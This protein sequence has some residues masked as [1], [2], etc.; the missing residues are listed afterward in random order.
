MTNTATTAKGARVTLLRLADVKQRTGIGKSMIYRLIKQNRF[1]AP[2]HP[3]GSRIS[4]WIAGEVDD[5]L[6][7]QIA[8]ERDS[9]Q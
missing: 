6:A 3:E 4:A 7:K 1:P 9:V 2:I 5:W 8:T